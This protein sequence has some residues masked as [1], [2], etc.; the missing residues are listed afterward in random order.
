MKDPE[1]LWGVFFQA[2]LSGAAGLG[3]GFAGQGS[4]GGG[5]VTDR[6]PF[7]DTTDIGGYT[8]Y[9]GLV[10]GAFHST[11]L[12]GSRSGPNPYTVLGLSG[13]LSGG[14]TLT[15]ATRMSQLGGVGV[16][17]TLSLGIGSVS[18]SVSKSGVWTI[19]AALGLEPAISFSVYPTNTN[20]ATV[21]TFGDSKKDD[22]KK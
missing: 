7:T 12:Q 10:G 6:N 14:V 1:G 13:G 16:T 20:T 19:T 11:T 4:V 15:N 21:K 18:W 17:N 9:G 5:F 22:K 8:S 3:S 2:D